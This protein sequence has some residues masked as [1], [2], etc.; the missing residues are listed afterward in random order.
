MIPLYAHQKVIIDADPKK[1]GLFLGT[2]SGKTRTAL[3]L[4]RGRTLVVCPKQQALDH[5][6]EDNAEKA[7]I[8]T[9]LTVISK[10]KF[11][12]LH[13]TLE[14]F[15]TVILDEAHFC[16]G[17]TTQTKYKK[18]QQFAKT[19][20]IYE[21]MIAFLKR[22]EPE[23]LYLCTATPAS[24]PLHVYA[25][26]Q[27]LG[28]TWDYFAFRQKYYYERVLGNRRIWL[29]RVH[30][31]LKAR[32]VVVVKSLGYIGKLQDFFDVPE[33]THTAKYFDLT[34][35]Q[36]EAVKL[37][38]IEQADP[39]VRRCKQRQIENGILYTYDIVNV[40]G[41]TER[42]IRDTKYFPSEKIEYIKERAEEFSKILIFA[43]Y[44]GQVNLITSELIKEGYNVITVT[45]Q[46]KNRGV[47]F[48]EAEASDA[49]IVVAQAGISSGY[50]L[51]SF[52]V[53][54][55]SSYSNK[56][57]NYEQGVGRVLRQNHLK[58]N[59]Y[60]HL[61]LKDG[62]DEQCYKTIQEG[63]DFAEMITE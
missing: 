55:F 59:L 50:E 12:K 49:C 45:G 18:G 62:I 31:D 44:T 1:C 24:K 9:D 43:E 58:K 52:P 30:N 51:P 37:L 53:V 36:R 39:M 3:E 47:I 41:R 61:V 48:K 46:T 17:V 19:S 56:Y 5:T 25:L 11:K 4:A 57:L 60:L 29:P 13:E 33:Q 22:T 27:V 40:S 20:Q 6:W 63:K 15:D 54:I 28:R 14:R 10:E 42:M 26:A 21:S 16:S 8:K 32:L 2:G 38:K 34:E 7:G 23:R 35:K